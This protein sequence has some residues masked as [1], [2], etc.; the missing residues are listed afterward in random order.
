MLRSVQKGGIVPRVDRGPRSEIESDFKR[1]CLER[2][3]RNVMHCLWGVR[4]GSLLAVGFRSSVTEIISGEPEASQVP[5]HTIVKKAAHYWQLG[6]AK[7]IVCHPDIALSTVATSMVV[8][9]DFHH[10]A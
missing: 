7:D 8:V 2:E 5:I 9:S 6:H 3:R 1:G 10:I 4:C